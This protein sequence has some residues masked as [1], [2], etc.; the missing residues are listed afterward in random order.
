MQ[1]AGHDDHSPPIDIVSIAKIPDLMSNERFFLTPD[2]SHVREALSLEILDYSFLQV[3]L[4]RDIIIRA[5]ILLASAS[6]IPCTRHRNE[7]TK[8]ANNIFRAHV[9]FIRRR[10]CR[11]LVTT[12][13]TS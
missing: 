13:R 2:L 6:S 1:S 10:G 12:R 9:R 5:Q 3:I 11:R 8:R 7:Q 4:S